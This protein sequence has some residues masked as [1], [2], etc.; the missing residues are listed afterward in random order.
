M[1]QEGVLVLHSG[2]SV[3]LGRAVPGQGII[4]ASYE[5]FHKGATKV[6]QSIQRLAG[7]D[8]SDRYCSSGA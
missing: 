1:R 2:L 7:S 8:A 3:R 4:F 6:F 5:I